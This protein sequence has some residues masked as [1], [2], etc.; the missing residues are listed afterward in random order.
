MLPRGQK[1]RSAPLARRSTIATDAEVLRVIYG[2]QA[3]YEARRRFTNCAS[4][5]GD[6]WQGVAVAD[7]ARSYGVSPAAIYRTTA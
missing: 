3:Y 7:L 5:E 4:S 2:D 1:L 6:H